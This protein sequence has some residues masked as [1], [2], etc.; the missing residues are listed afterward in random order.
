MIEA[1][2]LLIGVDRLSHFP[3]GQGPEQRRENADLERRLA[4]RAMRRPLRRER[5]RRQG[6]L[7]GGTPEHQPFTTRVSQ[8]RSCSVRFSSSNAAMRKP[9]PRVSAEMILAKKRARA[10]G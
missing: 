3:C 9:M 7:A 10:R 6:G 2:R 4:A 1:G 5:L 8:M